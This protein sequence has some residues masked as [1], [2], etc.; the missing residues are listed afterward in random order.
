MVPTDV[1]KAKIN[2]QDVKPSIMALSPEAKMLNRIAQDRLPFADAVRWF[3]S[4]AA[5]EQES[6]L[7]T[8]A[9]MC[10][11]AHPRRD[12]ID[13]AMA[14]A[15]LKLTFTPCVMLQKAAQPEYALQAIAS[16]PKDEHQKAFRLIFA[17]YCISDTR[18]R[19]TQC[20]NGCYHE[21][22]NFD[23]KVTRPD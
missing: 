10:H 16:L 7:K 14:L 2:H 11:Q 17:L 3:E 12:E 13:N 18:R 8:I 15:E 5:G 19:E 23:A 9:F 6:W 20:K 4:L 22:H 21:W 1:P